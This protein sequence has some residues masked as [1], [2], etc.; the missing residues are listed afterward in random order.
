MRK[1]ALITV[2][3]LLGVTV[4]YVMRAKKAAEEEAELWSEA[5]DP[6]F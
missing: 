2:M 6:V 3:L 4:F 1:S 5:L